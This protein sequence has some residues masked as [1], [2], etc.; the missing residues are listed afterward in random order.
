[1]EIMTRILIGALMLPV[2][3]IGGT[4]EVRDLEAKE[5][6]AAQ[7]MLF[8]VFH[9]ANPGLDS[10]KAKKIDVS[11]PENQQYLEGLTERLAK[12]SPT[13]VM[14]ECDPAVQEKYDQLFHS[15][16]KGDHKL[17]VNE[18]QQLGFRIAA[19]AGLAGIICYDERKVHWKGM[20]LKKYM[21]KTAPERKKL[22]DEK[23]QQLSELTTYQHQNFSLRRLLRQNNDLSSDREN[24]NLYLMH[25]DVGTGGDFVGAEASASWWHRNFRMYANIQAVAQPGTRVI[26]IAG[27]GHTAILK[28]LLATDLAREA[29][30]INAY[31]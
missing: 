24:M 27:Q 7:V 14:L 3:I 29:W 10:V 1:M 12:Q 20:E 9:F 21:S 26:A 16:L 11:A 22:Y 2:S 13:H 17:D 25:N 15:Y 4:T 5:V 23:I 19:Q 31:L 30:D 8:G 28:T 18:T 6:S